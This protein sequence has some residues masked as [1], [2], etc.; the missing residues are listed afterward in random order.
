MDVPG[1]ESTSY[2]GNLYLVFIRA[3]LR[4]LNAFLGRLNC[5]MHVR[6][7]DAERRKEET[8]RHISQGLTELSLIGC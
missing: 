6:D 7:V 8:A 5:K 2:A 1:R 3:H 4:T